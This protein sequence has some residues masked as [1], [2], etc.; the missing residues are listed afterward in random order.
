MQNCEYGCGEEAKFQL[1][2]GKWC[3]S[4]K[5]NSCKAIRKKNSDST[6][7]TNM[8][9]INANSIKIECSF[10]NES[11][12]KAN[13]KKHLESCYLNPKNKKKCPVCDKAVKNYKTS[14]T[15][16]YSCA[17][18]LFK[19]GENNG[20]WKQ[21]SYRTTCFEFHKKECVVCGEDKIVEVHHFD[22]DKQN[23][24]PENLIPLCP[25]HHQYWHSRFRSE[26]EDTVLEY[27]KK[28]KDGV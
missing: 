14:E 21:D 2:N 10:C 4:E 25:T 1:K 27:Q 19:T 22:E 26:I 20:N 5:F 12:S 17:N 18:K 9:V 3:C 11:Y 15:C 6:K 24:T 23:N 28:F 7:K 13:I 8:F 16:S